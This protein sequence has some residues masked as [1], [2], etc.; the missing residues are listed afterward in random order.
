MH[1]RVMDGGARASTLITSDPHQRHGYLADDL[2][3]GQQ[4]A[5]AVAYMAFY[6][7]V[8]ALTGD[9]VDVKQYLDDPPPAGCIVVELP[10]KF[11]NVEA[12][13]RGRKNK[14]GGGGGEVLLD[15]DDD[16][17]AQRGRGRRDLTDAEEFFVRLQA[18]LA[19][20]EAEGRPFS[21]ML[22]DLASVDRQEGHEFVLRTLDA[23][24]QELLPCDHVS[25]LRDHL[26]AVMMPDIDA[27]D[28]RIE[29]QRGTVTT[30]V[31]PFEKDALRAL[32]K[33]QHALLKPPAMRVK[34]SA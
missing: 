20:S 32:V 14:A 4:S 1:G 12:F 7:F 13:L 24:Q 34:R 27:R 25:R 11:E 16:A 9:I 2:Y 29:P 6:A 18:Q 5:S 17:D 28:T 31:Y 21:V 30:L 10:G 22:F 15:R 33:R 3:G 23:H 19:R 8:E 26:V